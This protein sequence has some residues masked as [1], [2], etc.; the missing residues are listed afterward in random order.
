MFVVDPLKLRE[1]SELRALARG[2]LAGK[3]GPAIGVTLLYFLIVI[4]IES[5]PYIGGIGTLLIT[6]PFTLGLCAFFISYPRGRQVP[7]TTMFSGFNHFVPSLVLYLL[8][9]L[10]TLL[11]M[12]LLIVPGIIASYRYSQAF[13]IMNDNPEIGAMEAIRLSSELMNGQ[14]WK[15]FLLNLSFIGWILLGIITL[16]I[17]FIWIT[18]YMATASANFYEDLKQAAQP[19][20]PS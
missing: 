8:V 13:Y 18:P 10:F 16:G 11:W 1:N 20:I 3:W 19:S 14:K 4:L 17:G 6:G 2:Q 12:L 5:I 9:A 15:L 7:F